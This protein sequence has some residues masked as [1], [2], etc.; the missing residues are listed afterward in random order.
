MATGLQTMV[1]SA[2]SHDTVSTTA[3]LIRGSVRDGVAMFRSI[4]FA[5]PPVG[6]LRWRPPQPASPWTG[7]RDATAFGPSCPQTTAFFTP[8]PA[9]MDEDCLTL[10]VWAP[11]AHTNA[12]VMVFIHG[13]AFMN[14]TSQAGLYD[15]AK[16]A[17]RGVVLVTANYRLGRFGFFAHPAL[18]AEYPDEA[19]GNFAFMDQ[20]AALEWVRDNIAAFGGDPAAVTIFGESSGARAMEAML[21]APAARGLFHK[22]I[23]QSTT[24]R[25]APARPLRSDDDATPSGESIGVEFAASVGLTAADA[26]DLRAL[27]TDVVVGGL[28]PGNAQPTRFSGPVIDGTILT[29]PYETAFAH[30][31][32]ASVPL[33]MGA[34]DYETAVFDP[35]AQ[36]DQLVA[37]DAGHL[38]AVIARYADAFP[39]ELDRK[40]RFGTDAMF[41]EPSRF[42]ARAMAGQG[43]P[44]YLYRFSYVA[45]HLRGRV[46]GALHASELPFVFDTLDKIIESCASQAWFEQLYSDGFATTTRD[47]AIADAMNGYWIDFATTGDPNGGGRPRWASLSDDADAMLE[48]GDGGPTDAAD[49]VRSRYDA[50]EAVLAAQR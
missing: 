50:W 15:G 41:G 4:P 10:N 32:V 44:A 5:T 1:T 47:Q 24:H 14:G 42:M 3:G 30:G 46:G 37:D 31:H 43:Q 40:T 27:P 23:I 25:L 2:E 49:A 18:T 36:Y 26:D 21:I 34:T 33:I 6:A 12:P 29:E 17:R 7:I 35:A 28:G 13:G 11:A 39:D 48:F 9:G 38:D 20:I 8:L 16:F 22:A 45:E 19:K